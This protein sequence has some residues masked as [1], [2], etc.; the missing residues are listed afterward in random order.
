[1]SN[2]NSINVYVGGDA[3]KAAEL[4]RSLTKLVAQELSID[5]ACTVSGTVMFSGYEIMVEDAPCSPRRKLWHVET[6]VG[7]LPCNVEN[8]TFSFTIRQKD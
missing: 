1:M 3:T 7:S 5:F 2:D 6:P 4:Y 8:A